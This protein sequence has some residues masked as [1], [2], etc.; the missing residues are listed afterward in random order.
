MARQV[1]A[2]TRSGVHVIFWMTALYK[3]QTSPWMPQIQF[4]NSS[5]ELFK[6]E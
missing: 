5:I 6:S 2:N 1:F 3:K 4:K